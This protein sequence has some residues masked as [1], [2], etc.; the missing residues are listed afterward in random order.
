MLKIALAQINPIVG[1]LDNNVAKIK[2]YI[3]KALE[4]KVDLVIFPEL[5]IVG[6]PPK[7]ILFNKNFK[8]NLLDKLNE[9]I[10]FSKNYDIGIVLGSP[11]YEKNK[12]FNSAL[13]IYN[14]S[15]ER[16][17]KT[18][19]PNYDVFDEKRYFSSAKFNTPVIFKGYK[20]ALTV[21]EDIWNDEE[22]W[23]YKL[24]E[25]DPLRDLVKD[26][27]DFIINISASPYH[28]G[29]K[30]LRLDMMRHLAF[31][32]RKKLIYVNQIGGNDDLIFDGTSVFINEVGE[33]IKLG[34]S[35]EE[36]L[37]IFDIEDDNEE[38]ENHIKEDISFVYNALVLGIR[39]YFKKNNLKK[40]VVGI[41][42]GIDSAVVACL[43][44]K[45]LG[46]EN[47]LGVFMP[48][49]YSSKESMEDAKGLAHNL[50]IELR[51]L[52][53]DK[54]FSN[55]LEIFNGGNFT[56][57]D[58]AEENLQARIRGI[59]LMFIANREDGIVLNTG[60]KSE[61]AMGYCT[62]Y[63]DMVG[64]LSAIGDL[65]KNMVYELAKYINREEEI[66]PKR[67][68][69]KAPSAELRPNQKDEDSL[70]PYRIL[71][72]I[73]EDYIENG[74]SIEEIVEKG[75]EESF[76]RD[77]IERIERNE[78]KRKQAP[79]ILKIT[80]KAFGTG[81]RFPIVKGKFL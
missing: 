53:I 25:R 23:G 65:R 55:F 36:D 70:P 41:S 28:Y 31:K 60:N 42:G 61:I 38:Y 13:L 50:G 1:G 47:V 34:K 35:F 72:R 18:L 33:V 80:P 7:D 71:D 5:A 29:K 19:L 62:L 9:L 24:Y 54:V 51:I 15:L 59:V 74:L 10:D 57:K 6:Y 52:D 46:K 26:N 77:V 12:I 44:T 2:T 66:I 45:A 43:A 40:A 75:Y 30:K 56:L 37:I 3:K 22:F 73:I 79:I 11:Y 8:R 68:L 17:D 63:G 78:Y 81:R 39:D 4:Q 21:C 64:A 32:Y 69:V 48:T 27:I 76:V 67:I 49:R 58:V 16:R 14:G 20:I